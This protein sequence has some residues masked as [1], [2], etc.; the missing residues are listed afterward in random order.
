MQR[1]DFF[2][3]GLSLLEEQGSN[4]VTAVAVCERLEVTRGSFY[5]HFSNFDDYLVAL[6]DY[7]S[8]FF[9]SSRRGLLEKEVDLGPRSDVFI[10]L[11]GA[12]PHN[13]ENAMRAWATTNP[14]VREAVRRVDSTRLSYVEDSL[15]RAGCDPATATLYAHIA[16]SAFIGLEARGLVGDQQLL[17]RVF[18]EIEWAVMTRIGASPPVRR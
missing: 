7:W 15:R 9:T 14:I 13:L 11:G 10:E 17:R 5:H 2:R 16:T 1:V 6:L 4:S 8:E 18:E 3:A 12:L